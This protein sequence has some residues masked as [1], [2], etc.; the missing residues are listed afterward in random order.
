DAIEAEIMKLKSTKLLT[1]FRGAP[2]ADVAAIAK[3]A[4]I[5]GSIMRNNPGLMEIDI[6]PLIV[7][8]KGEGVTALDALFVMQD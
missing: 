3:V 4:S 1:G 5:V 6:N 2:P 7:H 8:A